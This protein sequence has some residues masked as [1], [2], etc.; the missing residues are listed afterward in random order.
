MINSPGRRTL[1]LAITI[2]RHAELLLVHL[3]GEVDL[4]TAP[5][6]RESLLSHVGSSPPEI[7]MDMAHVSFF[8]AVGASVLVDVSDITQQ[9]DTI[10]LVR[11]PSRC[12]A[13]VLNILGITDGDLVLPANHLPPAQKSYAAAHNTGQ[14][15][16][17]GTSD[18][19]PD[20]IADL[21][22]DLTDDR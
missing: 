13:R 16:V 14:A 1:P 6:L 8:S 20:R 10:L 3:E 18:V 11:N 12:V 7:H 22:A 17:F 15:T 9:H 4:L 21:P 19:R 2:N 5:R